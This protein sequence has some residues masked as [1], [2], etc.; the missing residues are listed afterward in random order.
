M[1]PEIVYVSNDDNKVVIDRESFERLLDKFYE[2]GKMDGSPVVYPYQNP[3]ITY[4]NGTAYFLPKDLKNT[5]IT[6]ERRSD[7]LN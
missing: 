5:E 3:T 1:K 7:G 6:C 4:A 2:A